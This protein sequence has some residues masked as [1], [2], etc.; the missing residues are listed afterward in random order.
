[1][2]ILTEGSI[3]MVNKKDWQYRTFFISTSQHFRKGQG[4]IPKREHLWHQEFLSD[5]EQR[6]LC[7]T[8]LRKNPTIPTI[9]LSECIKNQVIL[10]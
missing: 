10:N 7:K 9:I 8:G 2:P 5:T 3:E 6:A 1:M 4:M